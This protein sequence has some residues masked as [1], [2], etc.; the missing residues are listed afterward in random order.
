VK[1][2]KRK[3]RPLQMGVG[4]TLVPPPDSSILMKRSAELSGMAAKPRLLAQRIGVKSATV[5]RD[6]SAGGNNPQT[7]LE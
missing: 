5:G 6:E 4:R 3:Q 2:R 1:A 7:I